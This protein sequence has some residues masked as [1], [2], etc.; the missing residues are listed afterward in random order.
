VARL[1]PLRVPQKPGRYRRQTRPVH[2]HYVVVKLAIR[3]LKEDAGL[4]H[5]P[6]GH[7]HANSAWAAKPVLAHNTICWTAIAG[8]VRV[9]NR[10]VEARIL[11]TRLLAVRRRL[12]LGAV[13]VTSSAHDR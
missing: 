6:S 11:R 13:L 5:F 8:R 1:A 9:D 2:R 10:L 7:F 4:E 12:T 3:D